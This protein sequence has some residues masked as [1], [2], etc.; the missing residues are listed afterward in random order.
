MASALRC[1]GVWARFRHGVVGE[2]WGQQEGAQ[3]WREI[4]RCDCFRE[5]MKCCSLW[6]AGRKGRGYGCGSRVLEALSSL[7]GIQATRVAKSRG[8]I[9]VGGQ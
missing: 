9:A 2:S 4:V 3:A 1:P 8:R 7:L 6:G 5:V